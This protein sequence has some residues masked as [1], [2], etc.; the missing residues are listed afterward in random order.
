MVFTLKILYSQSQTALHAALHAFRYKYHVEFAEDTLPLL[1]ALP[2]AAR[3]KLFQYCTGTSKEEEAIHFRSIWLFFQRYLKKN[4]TGGFGFPPCEWSHLV[5]YYIN[6]EG[7]LCLP[8]DSGDPNA[9][10]YAKLLFIFVLL[11]NKIVVYWQAKQ[12]D[13]IQYVE[14]LLEKHLH[15]VVLGN[16]DPREP[17]GWALH[18]ATNDFTKRPQSWNTNVGSEGYTLWL[19]LM[20]NIAAHT[21]MATAPT[22]LLPN[23][24]GNYHVILAC[25][26]KLAASPDLPD[27]FGLFQLQFG[28]GPCFLAHKICTDDPVAVQCDCV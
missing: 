17:L 3:Q 16:L 14:Q 10:Q 25:F 13:R 15:S 26:C 7:T 4:R 9:S 18:H 27:D 11:G 5:R 12:F 6:E 21:S 24:G 20:R 2:Q 28:L 22:E 8:A 23:L 1:E 19:F